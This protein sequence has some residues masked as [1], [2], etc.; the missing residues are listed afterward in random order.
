M[1]KIQFTP[2]EFRPRP[3]FSYPTKKMEGVK[4]S[5]H[6]YVL[7]TFN[8]SSLT[9]LTRITPSIGSHFKKS[10]SGS[11]PGSGQVEGDDV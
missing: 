11:G 8:S 5:D 1:N 4:G 6:D 9:L 3:I 7:K 10:W 2:I